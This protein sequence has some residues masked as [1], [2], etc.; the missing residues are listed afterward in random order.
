MKSLLDI[1]EDENL[2]ERRRRKSPSMEK[3]NLLL[4]KENR[5]QIGS[6]SSD[7]AEAQKLSLHSE[8]MR[9]VNRKSD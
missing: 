3:I 5:L 7:P 6:N 8:K 2:R 9:R 4:T 1:F